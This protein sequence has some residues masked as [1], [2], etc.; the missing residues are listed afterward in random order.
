MTSSEI[1][2]ATNLFDPEEINSSRLPQPAVAPTMP[3][4]STLPRPSLTFM[5]LPVVNPTNASTGV[6]APFTRPQSVLPGQ[7]NITHKL[8][9]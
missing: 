5:G 7:G 1:Q 3:S 2:S 4:S 8:D 9:L 6:S